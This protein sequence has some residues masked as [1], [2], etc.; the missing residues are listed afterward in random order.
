V[1]L[2]LDENLGER[3]SAIL[4]AAGHDVVTV[5]LQGLQKT[6]DEK[7]I[8]VCRQ[9][10]LG[11][12]TLDM[13]FAN[14]LLFRP[15]RYAGIAVLRLPRKPSKE[16]LPALLKTLSKALAREKLEGTLWIVERGRI[17]VFKKNRN[18]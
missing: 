12:V 18:E 17:R 9:E 10:Q 15:S 16:D 4:S 13:G 11:L 1:R 8:E 5:P 7:L 2:K 6:E 3:G 14:T